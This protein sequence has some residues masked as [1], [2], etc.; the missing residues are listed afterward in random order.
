MELAAYSFL[1]VEQMLLVWCP[2]QSIVMGIS[3]DFTLDHGSSRF[4]IPRSC[5]TLRSPNSSG[6]K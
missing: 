5:M 1:L 6:I 4:C 3:L 2:N